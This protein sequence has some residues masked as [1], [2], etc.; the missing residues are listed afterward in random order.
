ML[1]AGRRL[2]KYFGLW[3]EFEEFKNQIILCNSHCRAVL[4]PVQSLLTAKEAVQ[5]GLIWV[6]LFV[7]G[8]GQG[9][10]IT[11]S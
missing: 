6:G 3:S 1:T 4:H 2:P 10:I 5:Q 8:F 11:C 9:L 7:G